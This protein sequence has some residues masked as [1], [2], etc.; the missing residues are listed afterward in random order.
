MPPTPA[1]LRESLRDRDAVTEAP[2]YL[3]VFFLFGIFGCLIAMLWS[4]PWGWLAGLAA[5]VFSGLN[6][7]CWAYMFSRHQWWLL[8]VVIALPLLAGPLYFRPLHRLGVFDVGAAMSPF[9]RRVVMAAAAVVLVSI[10]FTLIARYIARREH[11]TARFKAE[12]DVAQ[13]LHA[14][15]VPPIERRSPAF[16]VFGVSYASSEMGGDLIDAIDRDGVLDLV[17][18]D[19]SGHGVGAGVVMAM[20]KAAARTHFERAAAAPLSELIADLNRVLTELTTPEMFV[21][22]A[23]V[24]LA[25]DGRSAEAALAGHLPVLHWVAS[26]RRIVRIEN[27]HLPLGVDGDEAFASQRIALAPGD[28]LVLYTDGLVETARADGAQFGLDRLSDAA[29]R[30]CGSGAGAIAEGLL[31]AARAFGTS[32]DDRSVLVVRLA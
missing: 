20:V 19:V 6:A 10:G 16:E 7:L 24:R 18:A 13:R 17:L 21:T 4:E 22:L 8:V 25:S 27:A 29:A 1:E 15:L 11:Q 9:A 2:L 31:D 3:G 32:A 14:S 12:L 30:L 23:A 28:A 26:E 5:C